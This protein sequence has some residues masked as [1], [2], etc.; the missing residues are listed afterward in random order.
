MSDTSIIQNSKLQALSEKIVIQSNSLGNGLPIPIIKEFQTLQ[1][2][3][4]NYYLLKLQSKHIDLKFIDNL[5]HRKPYFSKSRNINSN[6][7]QMMLLI[8]L[9]AF[10]KEHYQLTSVTFK[11]QTFEI[12][13]D[14]LRHQILSQPVDQAHGSLTIPYCYTV[15][16]K[17]LG[18]IELFYNLGLRANATSSIMVDYLLSQHL[19]SYGTWYFTK[20]IYQNSI[21]Y[22]K[23]IN[24]QETYPLEKFQTF[25][26][27]IANSEINL[28]QS[29]LKLPYLYEKLMHY[30]D[31]TR[32]P[33]YQNMALSKHTEVLTKELLLCGEIKRGDVQKIIGKEQRTATTLISEL[34]KQDYITTDSPKGAIR[35]KFTMQI[36]SFV[37][38]KLF[39]K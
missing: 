29:Y 4:N 3:L 31:Y 10:L 9:Q 30:I 1:E 38:P 18:I 22:E 27:N 34:L 5:F 25:M 39:D 2:K 35:L 23:Y 6:Q 8:Q 17:I 11:H 15:H 19:S 37:F 33:Y 13:Q 14:T 28:L 32:S 36:A 20:G 21:E 26:L 12:I 16:Q 7:K 24:D